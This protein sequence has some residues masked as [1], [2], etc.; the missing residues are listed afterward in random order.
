[1]RLI[2]FG[3]PGSGKGTYAS[4][5]AERLKIASVSTGDIFREEVRRGTELGRRVEDYLSRGELVPDEITVQVLTERLGGLGGGGFILDGYPRTIAQAR[6]LERVVGIDAVILL[7]VPEWVI[8]ERLSSRRVCRDCGAVYNVRFLR[9]RR[10]GVCDRCGGPLYQRED[11]QPDV[12]R[13]RLGVYEKEAKPL[14]DYYRGR[15]P[16]VEARCDSVDVPPEPVVEE[17]LQKLKKLGLVES[18]RP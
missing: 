14:I 7:V 9:P 15:V 12:I 17:I 4:R 8:V 5:L 2:I 3:P 13:Q 18:K 11:D 1:M 10:E 6:A 16:I